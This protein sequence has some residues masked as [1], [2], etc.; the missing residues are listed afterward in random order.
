VAANQRQTAAIL[1]LIEV[2]GLLVVAITLLGLV[3]TLTMGVIERT[4]E[5]GILRCLGARARYVRQVFSAEAVALAAAGWTLGAPLGWLLSR[6]LMVFISH[7]VGVG[8][9][10]VFPLV[11]LPVALAAV[12][13]VTL[14]VIRMPL[15][16]ATRVQPGS[17]LRYQ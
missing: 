8:F 17:A 2:M 15:R 13:A 7:D 11:S 12:I 4:R 14:A 6:A 3:S 5:I 1:L 16:R 10:V 9:P